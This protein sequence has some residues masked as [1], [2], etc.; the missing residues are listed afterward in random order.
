[1]TGTLVRTL[2]LVNLVVAVTL[3]TAAL[4]GYYTRQELVQKDPTAKEADE[5]PNADDTNNL[6]RLQWKVA[7]LSA[8]VK[9]AQAGYARASGIV[10]DT[11][12]V[13]DFR[14]GRFAVRTSEARTGAFKS[15]VYVKNSALIDLNV[16]GQPVLGVD[17]KPVRGIDTVQ[18]ELDKTL[19]DGGEFL[20]QSE[21]RRNEFKTVADEIDVLDAKTVKQKDILVQLMDEFKYLS[22]RRTDWDEQVRTLTKRAGQVR[23]ALARLTG[24]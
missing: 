2:I 21:Q 5:D 8:G 16:D 17:L 3:A 7:R 9:A 12:L 14:A 20:K 11:E 10:S 13:R 15:F 4:A 19:R 18:Q 24:K 23:D 22:D 6:D 1:M